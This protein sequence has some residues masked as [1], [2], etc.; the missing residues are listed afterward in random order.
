VMECNVFRDEM[1]D[2]LYGEADAA[3]RRRLE[4]HQQS[5]AGCREE[6]SGLRRLRQDLAAWP[7]PPALRPHAAGATRAWRPLAVAAGVILALGGAL[8]LSGSELRY[9]QGRFAFRLGRESAAT[10]DGVVE[11]RM[12]ALEARHRDEM[13][14]LRAELA[15][16]KDR[17]DDA[18]LLARVSE[19]IRRS[20]AR[21][22]AF[23]GTSLASL[24]DET[25]AQRRY[26]LAQVGAGLSFLEGKTGLQAAR[27][28][29]L[30]GHVLQA[31]QKR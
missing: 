5:C 19:M 12:A 4:E 23:V 21:Q 25:D 31:A 6:L 10:P 7:L 14:A 24:R 2:V 13:R 15:R 11:Q 1:L 8:G 30:M 28:T 27:T 3:T 20:E 9:G 22:T 17:D 16:M 18:V 29:E 26:D